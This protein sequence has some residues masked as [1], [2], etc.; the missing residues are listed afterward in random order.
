MNLIR[1]YELTNSQNYK[2][3][4]AVYMTIKPKNLFIFL[5]N[6]HSMHIVIWQHQK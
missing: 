4:G 3:E 6:S 1:T 5:L 2:T